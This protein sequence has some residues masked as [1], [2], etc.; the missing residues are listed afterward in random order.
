APRCVPSPNVPLPDLVR[1][2]RGLSPGLYP[3]GRGTPDEAHVKAGL[4]QATRIQPLDVNGRPSATG[5]IV[6]LSI[7]MSN[8]SA[9]FGRF[10]QEA[11]ATPAINRRLAIVNGALSGA[12]STMWADPASPAWQQARTALR[13]RYSP[14]QVQAIWM[15]HARLRTVPFPEEVEQFAT[16]LEAVVRISRET[17]PNLRII[18]VS[19]R[20]RSGA[21]TRRGPGEPQA[22]ETAFA[23]RRLIERQAGAA[24]GSR[25]PWVTW[26]PYLWANATPR[27]DGLVWECG[28]LQADLLHPSDSGSLKVAQQLMA[29]FMT[30]PTAAPWFL[31]EGQRK[32]AEAPR[33][34]ASSV[35]G[36]APLAVDF[37]A[38]ADSAG[39]HYWSFGD[40]TSS[41][42]AKPRKTFYREGTYEVRLTVTDAQGRWS[43][44][45]VE[46]RV[47]R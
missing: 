21:E 12:D 38:N 16:D 44:A 35:A 31:E 45:S 41:L 8:T 15:K 25:A 42:V 10:V 32:G 30:E 13:G 22:Y 4:A 27:S 28:D 47:E 5:Q 37:G 23:V 24:G 17:F 43:R 1:S 3:D 14:A 9:E 46:V 33:I 6:L 20:T 39:R 18:Y 26:G 36:R 7:G 40:G 11:L 2:Y 29:F 34:E 19:S